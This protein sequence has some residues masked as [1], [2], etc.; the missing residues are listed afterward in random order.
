MQWQFTNETT[1]V[2]MSDSATASTSRCI[3]EILPKSHNEQCKLSLKYCTPLNNQI[4]TNN[5]E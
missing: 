2:L 1:I 5:S 4:D 3:Q